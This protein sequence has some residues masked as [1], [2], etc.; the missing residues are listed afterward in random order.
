M[1]SSRERPSGWTQVRAG[2]SRF[3]SH[4]PAGLVWYDT[5]LPLG[6]AAKLLGRVAPSKGDLNSGFLG[7]S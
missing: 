2:I 3:V 7:T 4:Q 5:H 6:R 1:T